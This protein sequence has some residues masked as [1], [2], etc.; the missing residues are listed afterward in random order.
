MTDPD[1][2]FTE[3]QFRVSKLRVSFR[4]KNRGSA[5][6][7]IPEHSTAPSSDHQQVRRHFRSRLSS[8]SSVTST[9]SGIGGVRSVSRA[10]SSASKTG[11]IL[12]RIASRSRSRASTST[13]NAETEFEGFYRRP[14]SR[15]ESSTSQ[16][17][18]SPSPSNTP[19][20]VPST[21]PRHRSKSC[22]SVQ[23]SKNT[24]TRAFSDDSYAEYSDLYDELEEYADPF[25][26][27]EKPPPIPPRRAILRP[28]ALPP[29]P[30]TVVRLVNDISRTILC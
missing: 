2:D 6:Q 29:Y 25:S 24:R 14:V 9:D 3:Y 20:R 16:S 10:S 22:S 15:T 12:R 11:Q 19:R 13:E 7:E 8:T 5:E 23:T 26:E 1:P 30:S 27:D 17:V 28:P 18:S 4:V 21:N